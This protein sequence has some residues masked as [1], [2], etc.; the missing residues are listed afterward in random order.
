[1]NLLS[2]LL[3]KIPADKADHLKIGAAAAL[4]LGAVVLLGKFIGLSWA[5]GAGAIALGVGYEWTQKRRGEGT[6]SW[7]D[8]GFSAA[9]GVALAALSRLVGLG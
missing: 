5:I 4:A 2:K 1:M 6:V 7:L 3:A 9:P 8:A